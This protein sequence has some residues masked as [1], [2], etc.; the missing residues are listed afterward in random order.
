MKVLLA[1]QADIAAE[2]FGEVG[3]LDGL[4][5]GD[6]AQEDREADVAEPVLALRVHAQVIERTDRDDRFG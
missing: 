5:A 6:L 4:L 1:R 3:E 2:G